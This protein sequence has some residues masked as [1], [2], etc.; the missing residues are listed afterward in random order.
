VNRLMD[1]TRRAGIGLF[2]PISFSLSSGHF[3]SSLRRRARDRAGQPLP[4]YT[5]PAID[6]LSTLNFEA[7]VVLE[8]GGG[9]STLWWS[10]R[11]KAVLTIES[12]EQWFQR[13]LKC[14]EVRD[15]V[16][17]VLRE[18]LDEF[19]A[20]PRGREFD[21]VV[22]DGGDRRK[23][24]ETALTVV[25]SDGMV[26]LDD[27]QGFWGPEGSYPIVELFR[28][29][30]FSRVDFY[31]YAPAVYRPHCTSIFFRPSGW[32]FRGDTPPR[33]T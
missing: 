25:A 4:W 6:F 30:G 21:I 7:R 33:R 15:H 31:G 2:T 19:A 12:D 17:C 11:A 1:L 22:I 26:I 28:S 24:A 23:C 8:F 20:Y 10:R 29:S 18:D 13:L 14:P 9:Q 27:S 16:T 3:A 5:Y 32:V